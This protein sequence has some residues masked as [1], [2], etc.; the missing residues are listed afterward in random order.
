[1][2]EWSDK[3]LKHCL[4]FVISSHSKCDPPKEE[5]DVTNIPSVYHDLAPV[6]SKQ[7]TLLLLPHRPYDCSIDLLPGISLPATRLYN[8]SGPEREFMRKYIEESLDSGIICPSTYP[9][10][11]RY[12]FVTKNN[13][14]FRQCIDY[15]YLNNIAIKNKY[16]LPLTDMNNSNLPPF[17][18]NSTQEMLITWYA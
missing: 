9:V 1:M 6:F 14:T 7:R 12:F 4:R 10:G 2:G 18:P 15:R 16:P 5:V 3:C 8:L 11:A 17:S 13:K